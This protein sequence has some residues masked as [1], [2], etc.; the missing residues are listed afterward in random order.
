M[1]QTLR[2]RDAD[3]VTSA[4]AV[5]DADLA[6]SQMEVLAIFEIARGEG[7][8]AL[9]EHEVIEWGRRLGSTYSDQRLRSCCPELERKRWLTRTPTFKPGPTGTRRAEVWALAR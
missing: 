5:A 9:A 3:P 4:E 7:V 6:R 8:T 1:G 2:T